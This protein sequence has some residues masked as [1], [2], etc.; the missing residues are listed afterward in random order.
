MTAQ[1]LA[2]VLARVRTSPYLPGI[3]SRLWRFVPAGRAAP[4]EVGALGPPTPEEPEQPPDPGA[5]RPSSTA[6]PLLAV[7][8][9]LPL[10]EP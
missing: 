6:G 7:I 9:R 8:A 5:L 2:G 4:T 10:D 3:R 1:G